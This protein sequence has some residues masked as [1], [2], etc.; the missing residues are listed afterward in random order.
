MQFQTLL[1][2]AFLVMGLT[3]EK[4]IKKGKKTYR[5]GQAKPDSI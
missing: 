5:L 3:K 1:L 2:A 4:K